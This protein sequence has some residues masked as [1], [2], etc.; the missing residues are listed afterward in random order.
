MN[1]PIEKIDS[2]IQC[3]EW[4]MKV[5]RGQ[6]SYPEGNCTCELWGPNSLDECKNCI[7]IQKYE[8]DIHLLWVHIRDLKKIRE[9]TKEDPCSTCDYSTWV[10][11]EDRED[12]NH[13]NGAQYALW[14]GESLRTRDPALVGFSVQKKLTY[15]IPCPDCSHKNILSHLKWTA[16]RCE[17]C[18]SQIDR[19]GDSNG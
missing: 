5:A 9:G 6:I 4:S 14:D 19:N 2:V 10:E 13:G 11:K 3:L 7:L 15:V 8:D 16:I 18:G 12:P 1:C 17:K